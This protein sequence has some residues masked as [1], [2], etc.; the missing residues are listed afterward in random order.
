[1]AHLRFR[2]FISA[3][4]LIFPLC[5][6]QANAQSGTPPLSADQVSAA[7]VGKTCT[8]RAGA[9]FTF[10]VDGHYAYSGQLGFSHSGHYSVRDGGVSVQLDSGLGR[11]FGVSRRNDGLYMEQT[12]IHCDTPNPKNA[13]LS[14]PR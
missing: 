9:Q 13:L 14:R 2:R 7:L 1:M 12:A 6:L 5:I 11:D 3:A 8:S 4:A 10:T